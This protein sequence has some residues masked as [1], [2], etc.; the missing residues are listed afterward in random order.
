VSTSFNVKKFEVSKGTMT[1]FV[2]DT[3]SESDGSHRLTSVQNFI[4][5]PESLVGSP[6][7][8]S[9]G[10]AE[11]YGI[12]SFVGRLPNQKSREALRQMREGQLNEHSTLS[13]LKDELA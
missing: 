10:E 3:I 7:Y 2:Q 8:E 4:Q 1:D 9:A 5:P 12:E 6:H 11:V 13:D